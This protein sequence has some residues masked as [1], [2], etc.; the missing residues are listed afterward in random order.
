MADYIRDLLK[1]PS[2]SCSYNELLLQSG[3][4]TVL[5]VILGLFAAIF[6]GKLLS[7]NFVSLFISF[8][9]CFLLNFLWVAF[10]PIF[11]KKIRYVSDF[12]EDK[13]HYE[14][15]SSLLLL[16]GIMAGIFVTSIFYLK[17][18]LFIQCVGIFFSFVLPVL[19]IFLKR[20]SFYN[21]NGKIVVE[22]DYE[23][24]YDIQILY[25]GDIFI[26][27]ATI[28]SGSMLLA[29]S[30]YRSYP[31]L[32]ISVILVCLYVIL[33]YAILRPDFWNRYLP[34]DIKRGYGFIGYLVICG[35]IV[36]IM[37]IV[38]IAYIG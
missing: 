30:L 8:C 26:G 5:S 24:A 31:P 17:G 9:L 23:F 32:G 28:G 34:F 36:Y 3:I 37:N 33:F 16:F 12:G 19:I 22:N 27:L 13:I 4:V 1:K 35:L 11:E 15:R 38:V 21:E 2:N 14:A 10:K 20:D 6:L 7:I 25:V 29:S 18:F